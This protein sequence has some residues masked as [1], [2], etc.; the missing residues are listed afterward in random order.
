MTRFSCFVQAVLAGCDVNAADHFGLRP[1]HYAAQL[2][3]VNILRRLL[4]YNVDPNVLTTAGHKK[5]G[6]EHDKFGQWGRGDLS[7]LMLAA[8]HG[9]EDAI[10]LLLKNG[11]KTTLTNSRKET[12]LHFAAATPVFTEECITALVGQQTGS[13][14]ALASLLNVQVFKSGCNTFKNCIYK[15]C[16]PI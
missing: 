6:A 5:C 1:V 4:R 16:L 14:R 10:R 9:R 13:S 11:A 3:P 7:P 15:E 12:A 8:S 2:A